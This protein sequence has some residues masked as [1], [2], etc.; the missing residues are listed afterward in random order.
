MRHTLISMGAAQALAGCSLDDMLTHPLVPGDAARVKHLASTP[1][2]FRAFLA[3]STIKNWTKHHRTHVEHHSA[4]G[5]TWECRPAVPR[6]LDDEIVDGDV[7]RL[8]GQ[9]R[10]PQ[11]I[12]AEVNMA[13]NTVKKEIG[14][15]PLRAKN[16]AA[17]RDK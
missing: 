15:G 16:K 17:W 7:L 13:L 10:F 8:R 4:D 9:A 5:Q 12:P 1:E 6:L 2:A 14:L 3:D 11:P